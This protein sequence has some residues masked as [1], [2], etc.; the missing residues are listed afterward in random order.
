MSPQWEKRLFFA[1]EKKHRLYYIRFKNI[2][3]Y[4]YNTIKMENKTINTSYLEKILNDIDGISVENMTR[5]AKLKHLL[6]DLD[7]D[8][9]GIISDKKHHGNKILYNK[10]KFQI[11]KNDEG[12]DTYY[13]DNKMYSAEEYDHFYYE[14]MLK[15]QNGISDMKNRDNVDKIYDMMYRLEFHSQMPFFTEYLTTFKLLNRISGVDRNILYQFTRA[16]ILGNI[17]LISSFYNVK[18][19]VIGKHGLFV[20]MDVPIYEDK[21]K[22]LIPYNHMLF[23]INAI[24]NVNIFETPSKERDVDFCAKNYISFVESVSNHKF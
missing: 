14:R 1:C 15:Y 8:D 16:H 19:N 23:M 22:E 10:D 5:E 13:C 18:L 20:D 21:Y 2:V 3:L 17:V 11:E 9:F 7:N 4:T 6:Q 12:I 24:F